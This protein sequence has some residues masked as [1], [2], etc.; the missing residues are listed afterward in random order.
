LYSKGADGLSGS[1]ENDLDNI[2]YQ[3]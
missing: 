3:E 2:Y 1:D